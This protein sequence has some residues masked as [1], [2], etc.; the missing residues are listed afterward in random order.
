MSLLDSNPVRSVMQN[1]S[2]YP[3]A[4]ALMLAL[5]AQA[6]PQ[7]SDVAAIRYISGGVG[8]E[9][10]QALE[11]E[12]VNNRLKMV[13]TTLD[14]SYIADIAVLVLDRNKNILL[15]ANSEGPVMM[16]DLPPGNYQVQATYELET[17]NKNVVTEQNRLSTVYFRFGK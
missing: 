1:K 4:L 7:A 9:E 3:A 2:I 16:I 6:G 8:D 12:Q 17:L 15:Q 11:V 14:G 5:N 10:L 13:F